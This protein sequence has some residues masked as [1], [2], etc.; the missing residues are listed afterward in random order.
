MLR[1]R[2]TGLDFNIGKC[3]VRCSEVLFFGN[4]YSSTGVRPDPKKVQAINDLQAPTNVKELQSF[5]SIVTYLASY[6]QK[7]SERTKSLHEL[8][9]PDA[10]FQWLS[11]HQKAIMTV[12]SLLQDAGTLSYFD[13][14]LPTMVQVDASRSEICAMLTQNGKPIMFASK[15]LTK[16][17]FGM[18]TLNLKCCWHVCSAQSDFTLASLEK[19]F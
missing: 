14:A 13:P 1:T 19:L 9:H 5:L 18:Q 8:L 16:Q 2:E 7:L 17:N 3:K 6:I 10:A 15:S 11:E 4:I 12:K